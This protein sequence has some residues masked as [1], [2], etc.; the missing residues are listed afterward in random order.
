VLYKLTEVKGNRIRMKDIGS[1]LLVSKSGLSR[2]VDEIEKRGYVKRERCS[3]DARGFEVVLTASGRRAYR[4]AEKA[5]L[6]QLRSAFLGRLSD[7]QLAALADIWEI[8]GLC[9]PAD[10]NT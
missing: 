3:T 10:N 4:R 6:R 5:F 9:G 8:T 7:S 1:T 2:V